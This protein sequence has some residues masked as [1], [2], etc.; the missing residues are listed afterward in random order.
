VAEG[1]PTPIP[2]APLGATL[3]V[4]SVPGAHFDPETLV[5]ERLKHFELKQLLGR[6]GMGAVYLAHDNSLDRPVALK[7]LAPEVGVDADV[8]ARFVR[9]ARAQAR[10][11]H[12]NVTQ[13][14]FIG[15]DRGL[16]F[17][18]ME[19]VDGPS[20]AGRLERGERVPWA[21]ALE[22]AIGAAEGLQAAH[23]A[24]FVHRDVKPSNLL[25]D[26][27]GQVKIADF[28]LVKSLR[29]DSQLTQ[30]GLI[31][32]SPLYMA[33][34]QGRAEEV[35]H[36]SDIYSLGCTLY[37]LIA[38]QPP[39]SSDSPVAVLSMHV[40]DR[41]TRIRSLARET[42]ENVERLVDRMMAKDRTR[43]FASYDDLLVAMRAARPGAREHSGF[44]KRGAALGIDLAIFAALWLVLGWWALPLASIYFVAGHA[45]WGRTAGKLLL[46]LQV[47]S[48]KGDKLGWRSA[49][50]RFAVFAWGPLAWSALAALVYFL[51]RGQHISFTLG[52]L[53]VRE[54]WLPLLYASIAAAIFVAQL[55]GFLLAAFHPQKRALHDLAAGSEVVHR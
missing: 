10:L 35:D 19:F 34:E 4:G 8:V 31:V 18:A 53:T 39:F 40:T 41:A 3:P 30:A 23:A 12:P 32:G 22:I 2:V 7:V 43:R 42:P 37:H 29:G 24:G 11:R 46:R 16:H 15:E 45:L 28:G 1:K 48:A 52:K 44:W 6:G 51:H 26:E 5:G 38:G 17:F 54:A 36:R 47:L 9:E 50:V 27:R 20:P 21:E 25:V 49:L 55:G 14:Y 33:P 13:I